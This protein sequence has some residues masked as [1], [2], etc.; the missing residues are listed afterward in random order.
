MILSDI[1]WICQGCGKA[2]I[3]CGG[4]ELTSCYRCGWERRDKEISKNF[5][6]IAKWR[7]S[8]ALIDSPACKSNERCCPCPSWYS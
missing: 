5:D 4:K 1:D 3:I 6:F 2:H 8:P 7:I